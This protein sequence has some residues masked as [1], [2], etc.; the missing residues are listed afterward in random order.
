MSLT[1]LN[2][3][4]REIRN[5]AEKLLPRQFSLFFRKLTL[6]LLNRTVMRMPIITG[7]ARGNWQVTVNWKPEADLPVED[8]DGGPTVEAGAAA[9][10]KVKIGDVVYLTN[11]VHYVL[12]LEEG[13]PR[14]P[15]RKMLAESIR[16][17][18]AIFREVK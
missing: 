15:P 14:M 3:F 1:N 2:Q 10:T 13:T 17:V 4:N 16:E 6:E 11:N 5:F 12:Y 9:V 8:K 18:S 7:R